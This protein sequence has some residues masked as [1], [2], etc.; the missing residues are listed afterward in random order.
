MS[1]PTSG[2]ATSAQVPAP[3]VDG[4]G[5]DVGQAQEREDDADRGPRGQGLRHEGVESIP[6]PVAKPASR[7]A[8]QEDTE[9]SEERG[10]EK[11]EGC[12]GCARRY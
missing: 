11:R 8:D 7:E 3:P 9:E 10:H 5:E 6:S 2:Q 4:Q 1:V 12:E